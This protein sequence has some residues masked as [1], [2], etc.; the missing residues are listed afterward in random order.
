MSCSSPDCCSTD[1]PDATNTDSAGSTGQQTRR[2][3]CPRC[4][5]ACS[6]CGGDITFATRLI[7]HGRRLERAA[8][9]A[10]NQPVRW[11]E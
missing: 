9:E 8:I 10:E 1:S 7:E 5:G 4:K 11:H 6:V 2:I 3:T